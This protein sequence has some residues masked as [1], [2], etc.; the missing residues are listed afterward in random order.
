MTVE[1]HLI[2]MP[3]RYYYYIQCRDEYNVTLTPVCKE[4]S[5][6]G[7]AVR[8]GAVLNRMLIDEYKMGL[9]HQKLRRDPKNADY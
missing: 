1:V 3:L 4:L 8:G 9:R 2:A 5:K 7:K 6:I